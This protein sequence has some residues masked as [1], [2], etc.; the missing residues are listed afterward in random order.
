MRRFAWLTAGWLNFERR[1]WEWCNL[2]E[3]DIYL[4]IERQHAEGYISSAEKDRRIEFAKRYDR[5][6]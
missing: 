4:A 5:T 1:Q 2:D 6:A 3:Q